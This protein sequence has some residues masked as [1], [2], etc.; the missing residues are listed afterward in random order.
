MLLTLVSN[1]SV[2][3]FC[4]IM[5]CW[6]HYKIKTK[7]FTHIK[8]GSLIYAVIF[9]KTFIGSKNFPHDFIYEVV[10]VLIYHPFVNRKLW[11]SWWFLHK[12]SST[13]KQREREFCRNKIEFTVIVLK[14]VWHV[15]GKR[16]KITHFYPTCLA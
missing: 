2:G 7:S 6:T 11:F 13:E 9:G 4:V 3:I 14:S 5:P 8:D 12:I 15:T 1:V 16:R 10:P